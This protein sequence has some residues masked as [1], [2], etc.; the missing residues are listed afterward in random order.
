MRLLIK[1]R[2]FSWTDTYDVY[3]E[4][5]KPKYFVRAE[6]FSWGHKIHVYEHS[7]GNE[8]GMIRQQLLTFL[9]KFDVEING[10]TV[11]TIQKQFS[12]FKPQYEVN[13]KDWHVAGDFLAWQY[14]VYQGSSP[15]LQINKEPFHWG[16][17]YTIDYQNPEDE[18]M[19]LLLV[20]AIDAANCSNSN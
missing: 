12:L 11:G 20:I 13:C 7:T 2:V 5:E 6:L 15:I 4:Y 10:Q 17:T 1:Q 18:L 8:V 3:D 19:G 9:P 14:N 16:D